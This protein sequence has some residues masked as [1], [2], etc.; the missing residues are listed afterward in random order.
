MGLKLGDVVVRIND[1]P[2]ASLTHGQAHEAL[3]LAGNNF[4]LG[5]SR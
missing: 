1:R 3:M 2:V 5:V 4:T